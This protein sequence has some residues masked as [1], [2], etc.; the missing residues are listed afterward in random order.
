VHRHPDRFRLDARYIRVPCSD[1][2]TASV[3]SVIK[4][5]VA[6]RGRFEGTS[7]AEYPATGGEI[8]FYA[9]G[10]VKEERASGRLFM[11]VDPADA[12]SEPDVR[13]ATPTKLRWEI[14][15]LG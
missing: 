10:R 2:S 9:R 12:L 3:N 13:C 14:E 5:G 7:A 4:G 11:Y 1:G 15:R 8:F 6:R